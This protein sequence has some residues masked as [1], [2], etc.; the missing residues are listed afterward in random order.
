MKAQD[1]LQQIMLYNAKIDSK[2]EELARLKSLA[3]KVTAV[4]EGEVVSRSRNQDTM[5]DTVVKIIEMQNEINRLIDLYVDKKSYFARI[6]DGL[7]NP[8]YIRVLYGHY[9]H[10]KPLRKIADELGYDRRNVYYI[11]GDALLAVEKAMDAENQ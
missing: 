11:H 6:I 4:M 1:E 2:L 10:G 9:F 8:M 5:G 7:K 3:T